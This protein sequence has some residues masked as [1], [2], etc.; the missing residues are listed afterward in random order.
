MQSPQT[1][2]PASSFYTFPLHAV[3]IVM[4]DKAIPCR[5][6]DAV[7]IMDLGRVK[8]SGYSWRAELYEKQCQTTL[9]P[10]QPALAIG[11]RGNILIIIPRHC[12]LPQ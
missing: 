7:R 6:T 10:D 1:Q 2:R 3:S 9:L 4:F 12:L 8:A 11:R 5:V